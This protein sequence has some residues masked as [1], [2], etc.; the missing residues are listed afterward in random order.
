MKNVYFDNAATTQIRDEVIE[1]IVDVMKNEYG[2]PSS[3]H[4]Y[5]RSSK[6]LLESSRKEIAK[7]LN[8]SASEILFTS[9]GTEANNMI[10]KSAVS[11]LGVRR[12]ITTPIEHHAVLHTVE[13]LEKFYDVELKYVSLD[14]R[15]M[16][17]LD[18]LELLLQNS[19]QKTLVSLMHI[20]NEIGNIL[21]LK[22]AAL[23]SKKYNAFFHSDM[24]QSMGY[25]H[26]D[27]SAV[28]VDFAVAS[29]HKFHGPKGVGFAYIRKNSG[30][31]PFI[32]GGE[33]E[34][35]M[36]AGTEAVPSIVG[37]AVALKI[38]Y[39]KMEEEQ[40]YIQELKAYFRQQLQAAIPDV[41][42]NGSCADDENST[43]KLL[44]I[45]LPMPAEKALMLLFQLDLKGI[46]CSKGSACQ[47]GSEGGSH[48]L[49]A[50]CSE[51]D[52]KKPSLR[53]SFSHYNT[54]EEVDFVVDVLKE[55]VL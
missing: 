45:C 7:L 2:N 34:R 53:F 14:E 24:V 48:V 30:I 50:I 29:A 47:S 35:G 19:S 3:T 11:D 8:V 12:I 46:A 21:D 15:G 36:R 52:L 27:F 42:F 10:L 26:V 55:F 22:Q 4:S 1:R 33:Q 32:L 44:N 13:W 18:N 16:V 28:P 17:D 23:I 51:A 9:G 41:T 37:M 43:Y 6:S 20:N 5:G 25:Y 49:S 40:V 31:Q 38:S 39:D 54:K